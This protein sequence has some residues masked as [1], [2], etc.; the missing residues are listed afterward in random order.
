[1]SFKEIKKDL[2][3]YIE[4]SDQY[5]QAFREISQKFELSWKDV[6]MSL[7]KTFTSLEK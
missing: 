2:E 4:N 5:I 7:S 3:G 6:M 1:V